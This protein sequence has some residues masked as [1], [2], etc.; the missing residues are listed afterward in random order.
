MYKHL[1][2]PVPSR[3]LGMSLGIDLIPKKVCSLNCVYC[4]VG[5]TILR[6]P[7]RME[8]V[9]YHQV[10]AELKQ[11]MSAKPKI[12]YIPKFKSEIF[13]IFEM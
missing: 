5:K 1:F 13:V 9:K 6:T 2:R 11:F 10:I 3:R 8:Y 4:E 7:D 12:D